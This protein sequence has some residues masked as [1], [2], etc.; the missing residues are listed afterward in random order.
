MY[1][2]RPDDGSQAL[3]AQRRWAGLEEDW[4]HLLSCVLIAVA[5]I[6]SCPKRDVRGAGPRGNYTYAATAYAYDASDGLL[7]GHTSV[8]AAQTEVAASASG[9]AQLRCSLVLR[10][11]G[12]WCRR[13]DGG[14]R[15][16]HGAPGRLHYGQDLSA[17]GCAP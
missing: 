6:V 9:G 14:P 10:R 17:S 12:P 4:R 13:K 3:L 15:A 16:A 8:A 1:P 11:L 7:D 2:P 5:A